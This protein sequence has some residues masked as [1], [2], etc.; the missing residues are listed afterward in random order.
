[1]MAEQYH[2]S[3]VKERG[4]GEGGRRREREMREGEGRNKK[5]EGT[6]KGVIHTALSFSS[7]VW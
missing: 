1:M 7:K 3:P 5:R 4:G 2:S 6:E